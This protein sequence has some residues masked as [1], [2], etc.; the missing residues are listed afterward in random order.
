MVF[1]QQPM[2]AWKFMLCCVTGLPAPC[3]KASWT[4]VSES[5][6]LSSSA[7]RG[8]GEEGAGQ[9]SGA[10]VQPTAGLCLSPL[11]PLG[12]GPAGRKA[13]V[14]GPG[15]GVGHKVREK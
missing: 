15:P 1:H 12:R 14:L 4:L 11:P 10:G 13:T 3:S 6:A 9:D 5:P 7:C 2:H 8:D